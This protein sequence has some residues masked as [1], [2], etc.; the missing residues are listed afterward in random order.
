MLNQYEICL[1]ALDG[2]AIER[3]HLKQYLVFSKAVQSWRECTE[4]WA[5]KVN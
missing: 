4:R 1:K 2:W 5:R 3:R